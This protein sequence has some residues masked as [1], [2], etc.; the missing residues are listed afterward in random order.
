MPI[1]NTFHVQE[2]RPVLNEEHHIALGSRSEDAVHLFPMDWPGLGRSQLQLGVHLC[3]SLCRHF[4][5]FKAE[6]YFLYISSVDIWAF[7]TWL[8]LVQ[9]QS[10]R[11]PGK[12]STELGV[13]QGYLTS[14]PP[15][16]PT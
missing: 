9:L 14:K 3:C 4:L 5:L 6:Q 12:K 16:A 1:I 11:E 10:F 8:F 7:L 2:P 13:W 15:L